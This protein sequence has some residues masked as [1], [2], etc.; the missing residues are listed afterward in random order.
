ME[1]VRGPHVRIVAKCGVSASN[2]NAV[3]HTGN[4]QN[5]VSFPFITLLLEQ[6]FK[7]KIARNTW[8]LND[9][10]HFWK[11]LFFSIISCTFPITMGL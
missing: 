8:V 5:A 7:F 11:A 3:V 10:R 6:R 9:P 2:D 4:G 1:G